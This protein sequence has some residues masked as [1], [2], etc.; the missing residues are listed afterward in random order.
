MMKM[1][2][3]IIYEQNLVLYSNLLIKSWHFV[4]G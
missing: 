2:A 3:D 1:T 4:I